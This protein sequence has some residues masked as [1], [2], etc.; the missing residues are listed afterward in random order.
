MRISKLTS[1][2]RVCVVFLTFLLL[3]FL[4]PPRVAAESFTGKVIRIINGHTII[5]MHNGREETIRL[6]GVF[7]PE[8]NKG[9]DERAK[10][11]A[12]TLLLGKYV[13]VNKTN[14]DHHG[15]L[16][17]KVRTTEGKR[18]NT[19][20]IESGLCCWAPL[21]AWLDRE[22]ATAQSNARAKKLGLW[23]D[24]NFKWLPWEPGHRFRS[25]VVN[26]SRG[27]AIT[28]L[29]E[30]KK[31]TVRLKG[32]FCPQGY[33]F[34]S[35][36]TR[37][38]SALVLGKTVTIDEAFLEES[39][40][41]IRG[42]ILL[43]EDQSLNERLVKEG[44]CYSLAGDAYT[45]DISADSI[46]DKLVRASRDAR[47]KKLGLW[48][49]GSPT[50]P[51]VGYPTIDV[52]RLPGC[53]GYNANIVQRESKVFFQ[54]EDH[55]LEAGFRRADNC[56]S[57]GVTVSDVT[58][59]ADHLWFACSNN[60]ECVF[61]PTYCAYTAVS[62][63]YLEKWNQWDSARNADIGPLVNCMEKMEKIKS[64]SHPRCDSGRCVLRAASEQ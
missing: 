24:S 19:L 36:A 33:K 4:L 32:V 37:L 44:L 54:S 8:D 41:Q 13:K 22:L 34:A 1:L 60:D 49:D 42:V 40:G 58:L 61:A 53:P 55:A 26:V 43:S 47:R 11:L 23:A 16:V 52:Y 50:Q 21:D 27:D 30:G 48:A 63:N 6:N 35:K 20:L 29:H 25:K 5:V 12:S 46:Y 7:C 31:E 17:A 64:S 2:T 59:G 14:I 56:L 45:M 10:Q 28:V 3:P 39:S 38:A 15:T 18:I 51:I 62:R 9:G 57:Q